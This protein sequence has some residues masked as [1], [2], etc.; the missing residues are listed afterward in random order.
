MSSSSL[1]KKKKPFSK[2]TSCCSCFPHVINLAVQAICAALKDGKGLEAQYLL[3]NSGHMDEATLEGVALPE[4]VTVGDYRHALEADVVGTA[5]KLVAT[6]RSSGKR[7]E[8]FVD[9]VLEGNLEERWVD[10]DGN[11]ISRKALQLL[12]DCETRWSSTFNMVDRV[13]TMLPVCVFF[14]TMV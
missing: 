9:T 4:G 13:L 8:D 14:T 1:Q 6:C 7:R 3:G 5:R 12:R 10:E 11:S 2:L